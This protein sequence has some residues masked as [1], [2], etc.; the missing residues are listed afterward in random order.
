[1]LKELMLKSV[2]IAFACSISFMAHAIADS[3]KPVNVPAG[4]L[5]QG[6]ETLAK[7]ADVEIVYQ[8]SQLKGV[9]T[10][11]VSGTFAAHDAVIKLLEGTKLHL[12]TDATTGAMLIAPPDQV[13]SGASPATPSSDNPS[14]TAA[15]GGKEGKKDSSDGFLLAQMDQGQT[16]SPSTVEGQEQPPKRKPVQLEEVV[17]TGSRIPTVAGNQVQPIR[18]YTRDDIQQS[19]QTTVADFLNTLPD[20]SVS[21]SEQS[22]ASPFE[23]GQTTVQLH[24]LPIGTTLVLLNGR[25][26][27]TNYFGFFD[28]NDIPVAA[29]ERVDVLPVGASAVYGADALGGAVNIILRQDFNGA[30]LSGTFGHAADVNDTDA[31]FAW[32]KSFARGSFSLLGTYQDRGG[33]LGSQRSATST[34]V[35]PP[36][37]PASFDLEDDCSPGNVY[38]LN[39]QNLPGLPTSYAGIPAGISGTPT[40]QQF[41]GTA[42]HLNQCSVFRSSTLIPATQR[43]GALLSGHYQVLDSMDVFAEVMFS[44]ERLQS[45]YGYLIDGPGGSYGGT[46]VGAGN[47]YNPFRETVGVSFDYPGLLAINRELGSLLR[48]L[49]GIQGSIFSGWHYEVSAY[50]SHD[51]FQSQYPYVAPTALQAALDSSN[52][53]T[54]LNPFTTGAPGS[55]ELIQSLITPVN[56]YHPRLV[57][58]IVD[59]QAIL[60]GS[61]VELPS[62]S[63]QTVL[64]SEYS[65]ENQYSDLAPYSPVLDLQRRSYAM[66][67]ELRAPLWADRDS[68]QSLDRLALTL[69]GRYDHTDDF[70]GKATWQGG[71]LWRPTGS[72]SLTGGYGLS[73]QAPQLPQV[74]GGVQ[75][76]FTGNFAGLVDPFR[77]G[78]SVPSTVTTIVGANPNLKPETG[79]S[80]SLGLAYS[81]QILHGLEAS[82]TY[83]RVDISNYIGTPDGQTL[84]DYP[85]LF[86]GAVIRGPVTPQDQ[87]R[88]FLGPITQ[89]NGLYYNFGALQVAGLDADLRYAI[90]T[91]IGRFTPSLAVANIYRWQ[92]ALS[93][94]LPSLSYVS[95]AGGTPGWAPRWKGTATLAWKRGPLSA[96][97]AGRYV[98]RY[99]DYQSAVVNSNELGNFWTFDLNTRYQIGSLLTSGSSLLAGAYISVGAV[100]VFDKTPPFSYG[101]LAYDASEYDIRGRFIYAQI[102]V[103]F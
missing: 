69:A 97:I 66:F 74:D 88:G 57:D 70:G 73:Y 65:H 26:V 14:D 23:S 11:G 47:P 45:S 39:G 79:S 18:T 54:A 89:I 85:N 41:L 81:S 10:R 67:A 51:R 61:L 77:G 37:A 3:P 71:L 86:P 76:S 52:P 12:S 83:F 98:S 99:D 5:V 82:I 62:G 29:I 33:L 19:G 35:L 102:G 95:Q 27:P 2:V 72:L 58:Q 31:N 78:Q 4:D 80:R 28:L 32:G 15:N 96:M 1:V 91:A 25:R 48:P 68:T 17:V 40:I 8:A 38:S 50:L 13:A 43:E 6:L 84:I 94:G 30:E 56:P 24:G 49:L 16:S 21:S 90:E 20:V 44:N 34:T 53:A 60:R 9:R 63:L 75:Y 42:G 103:K 7:Q 100:N 93:P 92:S 46:T 36:G 101:Y 22:N 59:A 64:G 87:M 55:P